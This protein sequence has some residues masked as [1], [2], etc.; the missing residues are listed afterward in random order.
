M[1]PNLS[2]G[3]I[4]DSP[5][6]VLEGNILWQFENMSA[7]GAQTLKLQ[8]EH[9]T[10][11]GE[12]ALD[13][14]AAPPKGPRVVRREASVPEI[15]V[16]LS[17]LEMLWAY[18]Y[19][20]MV[21]YEE[22]VQ[23]VLLDPARVMDAETEKLI[24]RAHQLLAWSSSLRETY[25]PWPADLPSPQHYA[26]A[27][28]EWYGLKANLVF[29]KATAFLLSHERAHAALGHLDVIQSNSMTGL[30]LEMEKEADA[31]AYDDLLGQSLDD[32]E[33]LA[34]AWAVIS[35]MLSTLY[36]YRDPIRAL[37]PGGHP[38]LHHRVAYMI[39]RLALSD[40]HY[41]Y[42]FSFLCRLVLQAVFPET[43]HPERQFDD[44]KDALTDAFD[45]LDQVALA[46]AHGRP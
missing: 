32:R 24:D 46:Q 9:G 36:L 5:V 23:K 12:I 21:V 2:A 45:R 22:S 35:V 3:A 4:V 26:T 16:D 42:Y 44:W 27:Q 37:L 20:W 14:S 39:E 43:L 30:R 34:D 25:R 10:L 41:D 1:T 11:L 28:E 8:V 38:V 15:H 29:Q 17:H 33:K 40:Q 7:F 19:G 18:I 31:V 13:M 6:L